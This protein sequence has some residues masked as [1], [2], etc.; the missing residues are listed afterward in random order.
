MSESVEAKIDKDIVGE[1]ALWKADMDSAMDERYVD[2]ALYFMILD[3]IEA[4][5]ELKLVGKNVFRP[6]V[7]RPVVDDFIVDDQVV[8][9]ILKRLR[10]DK[11]T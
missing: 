9:P 5:V 6:E 3:A 7:S 10:Q 11:P 4:N 1:V 2:K 8:V